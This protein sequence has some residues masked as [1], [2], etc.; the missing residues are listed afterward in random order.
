MAIR[1]KGG[2]EQGFDELRIDFRER[3]DAGQVMGLILQE[4]RALLRFDAKV[5]PVRLHLPDRAPP[6][7]RLIC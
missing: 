4:Q 7:K 3:N 5:E 6:A 1:A 2:I